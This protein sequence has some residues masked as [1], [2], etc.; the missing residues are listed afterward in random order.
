MNLTGA[1]YVFEDVFFQAVRNIWR[2]SW[3][4][5]SSN[6]SDLSDSSTS[7]SLL[8]LQLSSKSQKRDK[9][10]AAHFFFF[11]IQTDRGTY[12]YLEMDS[13]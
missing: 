12:N 6:W 8:A 1:A 5:C 2:H 11:I 3:S 13:Q 10:P 4:K 9:T 7:P